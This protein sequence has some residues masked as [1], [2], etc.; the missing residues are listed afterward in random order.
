MLTPDWQRVDQFGLP[1]FHSEKPRLLGDSPNSSTRGL[2]IRGRHYQA[3]YVYCFTS[4]PPS[5]QPS[6]HPPHP[7]APEPE[8]ARTQATHVVAPGKRWLLAY[9]GTQ[10]H[11]EVDIMYVYRYNYVYIYIYVGVCVCVFMLIYVCVCVY[12][13]LHLSWYLYVY[14]NWY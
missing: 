6:I 14:L 8:L 9:L 7:A 5:L 11:L 12:L 4:R 3:G 2:L 10:C 13:Y 1:Y